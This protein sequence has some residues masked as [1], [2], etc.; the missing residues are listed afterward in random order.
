M[1]SLILIINELL[2]FASDAYFLSGATGCNV[3]IYNRLYAIP[4]NAMFFDF[5]GVFMRLKNA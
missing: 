2:G 1:R 5:L 3:L 4:E